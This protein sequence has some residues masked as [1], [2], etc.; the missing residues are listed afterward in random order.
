[1]WV[2][3]CL[4]VE[5]VRFRQFLSMDKEP[6]TELFRRL[7]TVLHEHTSKNVRTNEIYDW[8]GKERKTVRGVPNPRTTRGLSVEVTMQFDFCAHLPKH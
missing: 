5:S 1:M 8:S 4:G 7:N 3:N 6:C 2:E